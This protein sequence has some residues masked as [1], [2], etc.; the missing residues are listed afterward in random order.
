MERRSPRP[1]AAPTPRLDDY[2]AEITASALNAGSSLKP[3]TSMISRLVSAL[4]SALVDR[5]P[6]EENTIWLHPAE[7]I[8][9]RSDLRY[10]VKE[11]SEH[12]EPLALASNKKFTLASRGSTA[13]GFKCAFP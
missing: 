9:C 7:R 11:L 1:N 10:P 2:R 5:R 12:P 13:T 4:E 3:T 6:V 8:V